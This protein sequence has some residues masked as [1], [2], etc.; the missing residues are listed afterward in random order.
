[1]ALCWIHDGRHYKKLTPAVPYNQKILQT[2]R[3][4]YWEF[5][6]KLFTYKGQP[7]VMQAEKLSREFDELFATETDYQQLND[8]IGKTKAKKRELLLVLIYPELP[9]HN[10]LA[11]LGARAQVRK[12]DV[13]LQT[14]TKE[15]TRVQDTFLTIVETAKK[16][17]VNIY[18]YILDRISET[19]Y[20][21]SLAALIREKSARYNSTLV[22][23]P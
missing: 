15:G 1:M 6:R 13:S 18:D 4:R 12:R 14:K 23:L 19:Y 2:F 3:M 11:E 17:Q 8:R 9:L 21:P 5:Y 7:T 20:L 10:N 16:L 22:G